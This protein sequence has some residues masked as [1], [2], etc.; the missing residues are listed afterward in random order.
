MLACAE[1]SNALHDL[2]ILEPK[3]YDWCQTRDRHHGGQE[4]DPMNSQ[5]ENYVIAKTTMS[6]LNS[7]YM[8]LT[9]S[10]KPDTD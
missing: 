3:F 9:Y 7:N 4:E 5:E 10:T 1:H 2:A 6:N 8:K